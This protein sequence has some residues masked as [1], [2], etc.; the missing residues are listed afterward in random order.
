[1]VECLTCMGESFQIRQIIIASNLSS[2]DIFA[3][4]FDQDHARQNIGL[5]LDTNR[6]T[7]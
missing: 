4:S 1:M 7:L 6:L 2:A 5:D 3:D